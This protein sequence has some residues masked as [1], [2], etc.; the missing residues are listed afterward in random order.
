MVIEAYKGE[1]TNVD[2]DTIEIAE[3]ESQQIIHV[4]ELSAGRRVLQSIED[5]CVNTDPS[6][7]KSTKLTPHAVPLLKIT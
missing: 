3:D 1:Y 6:I 7:E 2:K 5:R 4:P